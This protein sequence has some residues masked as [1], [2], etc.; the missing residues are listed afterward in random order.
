[1]GGVSAA[2]SKTAAAPIERVK[3]LI[4]NQVSKKLRESQQ[5]RGKSTSV[6]SINVF[7]RDFGTLRFLCGLSNFICLTRSRRSNPAK[8]ANIGEKKF[9]RFIRF[10][11]R[12]RKAA[13][14]C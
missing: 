4:Q 10:V 12:K 11:L 2:V 1:M 9:Y 8:V 3:L 7:L 14:T 13:H 5:R 6:Q